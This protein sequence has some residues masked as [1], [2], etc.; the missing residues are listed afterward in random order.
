M[1][2]DIDIYTV[3]DPHPKERTNAELLLLK[4]FESTEDLA[5]LIWSIYE[6]GFE[7]EEELLDWLWEKYTTNIFLD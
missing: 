3:S 6:I 1:G 5:A 2:V 4:L 7:T